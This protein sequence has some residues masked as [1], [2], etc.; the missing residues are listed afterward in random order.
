ML[1][2]NSTR[3]SGWPRWSMIA[4]RLKRKNGSAEMPPAVYKTERRMR[5]ASA[6]RVL[7]DILSD[8]LLILIS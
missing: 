4:K 6:N 3:F 2:G 1:E 5:F 7:S 8:L